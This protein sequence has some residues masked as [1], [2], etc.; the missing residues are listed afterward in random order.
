VIS[1]TGGRLSDAYDL[2]EQAANDYLNGGSL[3]SHLDNGDAGRYSD[4]RSSYIKGLQLRHGSPDLGLVDP[5]AWQS[6]VDALESGA[7]S[8]FDNILTGG[9]RELV[10]PQAGLRF[11]MEGLDPHQITVPA[12]P[13]FDSDRVGAEMGEVYWHALMRDYPFRQ[14]GELF[15]NGAPLPRD[16]AYD[17]SNN[18]SDYRGPTNNQGDVTVDELFRGTSPG[19]LTGPY[20]S[21]LLWQPIPQG[22]ISVPQLI[23]EPAQEDYNTDYSRWLD[24]IEG[25]AERGMEFP[26]RS[27]TSTSSNEVYIRNGRDIGE[28]VHL[29]YSFEPYLNAALILYYGEEAPLDPNTPLTG[30]GTQS[31][32]ITFGGVGIFDLVTSAATYVAS[33]GWFQKWL[34]HLRARPETYAGRVHNHMEGNASYNISSDLLD[35]SS[36][37]LE[38]SDYNDDRQF[39]TG[40]SSGS[41]L[42]PMAYSEGSPAHPAYPSGHAIIAGACTTVLKALFDESHTFSDPV[43]ATADGTS[44]ESISTSLTV[45][46]E[47]NKLAE[48]VSIGRNFAGVHYRSDGSEGMRAGE[49][50]GK[51][52]LEYVLRKTNEPAPSL[53]FEDFDGNTQTIS[54]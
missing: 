46:G 25:T 43:Q 29:N 42:L 40:P 53:T 26:P 28:Y 15:S 27:G 49:Q 32:Y 8:D 45:G 44:L 11:E 20:V 19:C 24:V 38:I 6:L 4:K 54:P 1:A 31:P 33:A 16:A 48:N 52:L 2:R 37:L 21:Q 7:R 50:V 14:Y 23:D 12:A 22:A 39:D 41:Y 36:V 10:S 34:V 3:P 30:Q 9:E 47:L 18:F 13:A 51:R 17:L 5:N 35:R